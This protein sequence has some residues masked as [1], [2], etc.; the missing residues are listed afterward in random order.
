[1]GCPLQFG[2]VSKELAESWPTRLEHAGF[3]VRLKEITAKDAE[4]GVRSSG[5]VVREDE[6]VE[7]TTLYEEATDPRLHLKEGDLLMIITPQKAG[8]WPWSRRSRSLCSAVVDA[9]TT[10]GAR[11]YGAQRED[12]A[13]DS[14]GDSS[15]AAR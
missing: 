14:K 11:I 12:K 3:T 15:P 2:V 13:P 5:R 10:M 6:S 1:M 8:P 7:L 9:L 4:M